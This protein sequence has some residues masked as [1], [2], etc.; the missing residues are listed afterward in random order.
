[1]EYKK[2]IVR[3]F[4]LLLFLFSFKITHSQ[5]NDVVDINPAVN[6]IFSGPMKWS[7]NGGVRFR[8]VVL[9]SEV[10]LSMYIQKIKYGSE[11]CCAKIVKSYQLDLNEVLSNQQLY[12]IDNLIW[13]DFDRI[14]FK[15]GSSI[16]IVEELDGEVRMKKLN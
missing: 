2:S 1:M 4:L 5:I 7:E 10:Y 16:Y 15:E 12:N 14:K 13:L 11:N 8:V 3:V 9:L 6:S